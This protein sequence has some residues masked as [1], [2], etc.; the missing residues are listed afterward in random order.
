[1]TMIIFSHHVFFSILSSRLNHTIEI[2]S[3]AGEMFCWWFDVQSE[4]RIKKKGK[5]LCTETRDWELLHDSFLTCED[6]EWD[7]LVMCA[8]LSCLHMWHKEWTLKSKITRLETN[9][10]KETRSLNSKVDRACFD[11]AESLNQ[12]SMISSLIW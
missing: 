8:Y 12:K 2:A 5:R 4:S 6:L 9:Y 7:F 10:R 3:S 11:A 1:M